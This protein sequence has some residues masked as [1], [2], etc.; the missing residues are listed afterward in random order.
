MKLE[1]L[2]PSRQGT[3]MNLSN[4]EYEKRMLAK[5]MKALEDELRE[6]RMK[7]TEAMIE[8]SGL[9]TAIK[10]MT[11]ES[12]KADEEW[13]ARM[14]SMAEEY[15]RNPS[16]WIVFCGQSGAGKTHLCT[17]IAGRLMKERLIPVTYMLW[18]Q[19]YFRATGFDSEEY[20]NTLR[21][22]ECLYIDDLFKGAA[23]EK[24]LGLAFDILDARY[25]EKK[26]T[27]ISTELSMNEIGE[28][29]EALWGRMK[30]MAKGHIVG[31]KK[32]RGRNQRIE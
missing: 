23:P 29:D 2:M 21:K 17:A 1:N 13:K 10:N 26:L 12:F 31:I 5:T 3:V 11:F 4:E 19:D 8:A 32:E 24:Q 7:R 20:R 30:Q 25:R 18:R 14:K 15:A 28:V 27:I 6:K 16:G 22:C 9:S